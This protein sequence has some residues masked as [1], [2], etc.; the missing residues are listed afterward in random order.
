MESQEVFPATAS[1][2]FQSLL[3]SVLSF[4]WWWQITYDFIKHLSLFRRKLLFI[5]CNIII[6]IFVMTQPFIIRTIF[7]FFFSY[8]RNHL[9]LCVEPVAKCQW[10]INCL[11][12]DFFPTWVQSKNKIITFL[13][14]KT[15]SISILNNYISRL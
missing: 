14:T 9:R 11:Q 13:L 8:C 2:W 4:E 5:K 3:P 10:N 15:D 6:V 12:Y 7:F 1:G